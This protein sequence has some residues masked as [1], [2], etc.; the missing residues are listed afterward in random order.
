L[1]RKAVIYHPPGLARKARIYAVLLRGAG[2]EV[3]RY[4]VDGTREIIVEID[5]RKLTPKD[6]HAWMEIYKLEET[7]I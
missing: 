4:V 1:P 3:A 6:L 2:V 7:T 5:G